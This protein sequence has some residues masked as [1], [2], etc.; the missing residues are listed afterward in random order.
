MCRIHTFNITNDVKYVFLHQVPFHIFLFLQE[1]RRI[2][3]QQ[4]QYNTL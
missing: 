2:E 4:Q 3:Q 1:I